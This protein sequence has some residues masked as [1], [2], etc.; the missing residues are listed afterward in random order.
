MA[1]FNHFHTTFNINT[2]NL[3]NSK[4]FTEAEDDAVDSLDND[5]LIAIDR[6]KNEFYIA[7]LQNIP[8]GSVFI[9]TKHIQTWN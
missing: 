8:D 5:I 6:N 1:T 2:T 9:S 4:G 3:L 7:D